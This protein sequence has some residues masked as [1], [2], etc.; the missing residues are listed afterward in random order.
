MEDQ[1]DIGVTLTQPEEALPTH[2]KED[3]TLA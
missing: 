3:E 1:V 2:A